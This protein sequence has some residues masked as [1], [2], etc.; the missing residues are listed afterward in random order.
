MTTLQLLTELRSL[1]F[2]MAASG[3]HGDYPYDDSFSD[4]VEEGFSDN[5]TVWTAKDGTVVTIKQLQR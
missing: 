2:E 3:K 1:A 5:G 4:E